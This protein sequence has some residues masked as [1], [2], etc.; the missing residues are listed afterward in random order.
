MLS[1][2]YERPVAV[3][4]SK[5]SDGQSLFL[6]FTSAYLTSMQSMQ[7]L[8]S[9]TMAMDCHSGVTITTAVYSVSTLHKCIAL[10]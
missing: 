1:T 2:R 6:P 7:C 10:L 4:L 3:A 5:P 9:R 8:V